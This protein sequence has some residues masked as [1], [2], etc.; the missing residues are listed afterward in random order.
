MPSVSAAIEYL[1]TLEGKGRG[2]EKCHIVLIE[3]EEKARA[4]NKGPVPRTRFQIELD[5]PELYSRW[6]IEKD[7]I[8]R[9][10]GVKAVG[11][12]LM[13][14]AWTM[15]TDALIDKLLAEQE[16]PE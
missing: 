16:G 13:Y 3:E 12:D 4:E 15:L 9:R 5:D 1:K 11:L 2:G 10:A 6:H 14:R 8:L 7:R